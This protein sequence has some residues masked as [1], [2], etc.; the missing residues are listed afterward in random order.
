MSDNVVPLQ[1]VEVGE[2]FRFDP[3]KVLEDAKGQGFSRLLIVGEVPGQDALWVSGNANAGETMILL[4]V[5]KLQIVKA[6]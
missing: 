5:A 4:E 2:E 6:F 1:L 3:D